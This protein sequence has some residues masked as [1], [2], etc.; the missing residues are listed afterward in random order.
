MTEPAAALE[1]PAPAAA[2]KQPKR[3]RPHVKLT[4][5]NDE[6]L[7]EFDRRASEAGLSD[8][9]YMR[10]ATIGEAGLPR[11]RRRPLDEQGKLT[12]QHTVAVNRVG[13]NVN[14][15]IKALH[16][17]ALKAPTTNS[18]DRLADE[19]LAVREMLRSMQKAL[20][21]SLAAAEAALR[22]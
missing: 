6:E 10:V 13:A 12:A 22:R 5:Y 17:I 19:I 15:G 20:D 2:K 1:L 7:A 8:S 18:R 4:R 3:Q 11:S 16:E 21:Q 9:A 14:Q